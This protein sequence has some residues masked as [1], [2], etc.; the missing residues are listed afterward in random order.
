MKNPLQRTSPT[1]ERLKAG[2]EAAIGTVLSL[3][4]AGVALAT[5]WSEST[6]YAQSIAYSSFGM[7]EVPFHLEADTPMKVLTAAGMLA[8]GLRV[9]E[10]HSEHFAHAELLEMAHP[11][12]TNKS[13]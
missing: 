10:H 8:I 3:G 7:V 6:K 4:G 11:Q 9:L 5:V 12:F 1:I 13:A 2:G